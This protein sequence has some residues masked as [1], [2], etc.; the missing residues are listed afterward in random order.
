MLPELSLESGLEEEE[1]DH[2]HGMVVDDGG[3]ICPTF[4][5][6]RLMVDE[7]RGKYF[8]M[9]GKLAVAVMY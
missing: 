5:H 9:M 6:M 1:E 7:R 4:V 3:G 8:E 2:L